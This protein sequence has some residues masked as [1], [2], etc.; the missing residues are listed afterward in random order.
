MPTDT[1]SL[2]LLKLEAA[3][4]DLKCDHE[5]VVK[6][7]R[8]YA[9]ARKLMWVSQERMRERAARRAP[10]QIARAIAALDVEGG[11]G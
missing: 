5:N 7:E 8:C 2:V 9:L 11:E 6:A 10:T 4:F 3:I 1:P